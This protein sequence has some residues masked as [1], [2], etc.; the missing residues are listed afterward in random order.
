[1]AWHPII[2]STLAAAQAAPAADDS[3][4]VRLVSEQLLVLGTIMGGIAALPALIEFLMDARKRRERIALSIDDEDVPQTP[5]SLAGLDDLLADLDDLIDRVRR[6]AAYAE[7]NVGNEILIVGP[8]LLGKKTLARRMAQMARLDRIITVYNPRNPD[9]LAK[10][11]SLV[12]RLG[13]DRVMLLIPRVDSV[14][15]ADDDEVEAELDALIETTSVL[16]NVLVVGTANSFVPDSDVDNLFGV[17]VVLPG[18]A[19]HAPRQPSADPDLA[20]MLAEVCDHYRR[21]ALGGGAVLVGMDDAEVNRRVLAAANNPAEIEDIFEV[22]RT[23][24]LHRKL[25]GHTARVEISPEVLAKAIRRVVPPA[26][27]TPP[28]EAATMR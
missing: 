7:L 20:K 18:T 24:A 3:G 16:Q 19:V 2:L 8:P 25:D 23:A 5:I 17:K 27:G 22:A 6:P 26:L 9:A 28:G 21:R 11:K 10:A 4:T 13:T 14:F 15:E 1:M 12:R